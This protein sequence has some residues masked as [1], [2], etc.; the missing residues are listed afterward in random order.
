MRVILIV[1][2]LVFAGVHGGSLSVSYA[3]EECEASDVRSEV[4]IRRGEYLNDGNELELG[5]VVKLKKGVLKLNDPFF[6][7]DDAVG[8]LVAIANFKSGDSIELPVS[9]MSSEIAAQ[10]LLIP[11][12][13]GVGRIVRVSLSGVKEACRVH[14]RILCSHFRVAD[15]RVPYVESQAI[16]IGSVTERKEAAKTVA[17]RTVEVSISCESRTVPHRGLC[18][19]EAQI[20]NYGETL[21]CSNPFVK[22]EGEPVGELVVS[23]PDGDYNALLSSIRETLPGLS[24]P[25]MSCLMNEWRVRMGG[26]IATPELRAFGPGEYTIQLILTRKYDAA[27]QGSEA[28]IAKSNI[29][30]VRV[31]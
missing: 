25:P 31:E 26:T 2:S 8:N 16:E 19:V 15:G 17:V 29:I 28:V 22:R 21:K 27:R 13:T 7:D 24:V 10:P 18:Q 23:T 6:S 14:V 12:K 30:K 4:L 20:W 11:T 9:I 1:W 5:V 3:G